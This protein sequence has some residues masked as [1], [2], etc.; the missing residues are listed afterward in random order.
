MTKKLALVYD[1]IYPFVKGGAER[2][3]YELGKR[4]SSYDYEVHLYGM[5]FWSG[6]DTISRDGMQIHG[7]CKAKPL[8]TQAGRRS[9][10]QAVYFGLHC[11]K[12]IRA[13]F[14]VIDC[15]GFPYFS[16]FACKLAATIRRRP[17]Y[18]TWHEVWGGAYWQEY[19]GKL[20]IFGRTVEALSARLPNQIVT[21]GQGTQQRLLRDLGCRQQVHVIPNGVDAL[22]I[23]ALAPSNCT[24]DIIYVG[25][26]MDFKNA[27]VLIR[28]LHRIVAVRPATT[29]II[30]GD[31]PEKVRLRSLSGDL[32][33][34]CNIQ[35]TGF[36]T[37]SD[38]VYRLMKASTVLVLP[39]SREGFGIVVL[40]ANACGLPVVTVSC[41]GNSARDLIIDGWN[42]FVCEL[43]ETD[44]ADTILKAL[45]LSASMRSNCLEHGRSLDWGA[46]ARIIADVYSSA[47]SIATRESARNDAVT[48]SGNSADSPGRQP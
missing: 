27:D 7:I 13:D 21:D 29:C 44:I 20:S 47:P 46:V 16:L 6:P 28:A 18:S 4:L 40:E 35:F 23:A 34:D 38:D 8:Y 2:R 39:S 48:I 19:L 12:L 1:A 42:G 9:I 17:L 10:W 41:S 25:R 32:N 14:D 5:K 45:S 3:F 26:L 22:H 33:L 43:N 30:V 36:V 24:S 31:G 11:L 37:S 15:C